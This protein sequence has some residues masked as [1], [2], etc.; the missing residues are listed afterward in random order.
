M[1]M[2]MLSSNG[3]ASNEQW[4]CMNGN[5]NASNEVMEHWECKQLSNENASCKALEKISWNGNA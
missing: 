5:R 2:E 1:R 3:N 4:K